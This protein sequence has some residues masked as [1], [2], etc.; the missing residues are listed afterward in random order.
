MTFVEAAGMGNPELG[1]VS[2]VTEAPPAQVALYGSSNSA[3][4]SAFFIFDT[5]IFVTE[6]FKRSCF[7]FSGE[8]EAE[9]SPSQPF[10]PGPSLP[11]IASVLDLKD[12]LQKTTKKLGM[13]L[14]RKV[15][16]ALGSPGG[17]PAPSLSSP[18]PSAFPQ[19]CF[20]LSMLGNPRVTLLDEPSTGMD[21]KAKQHM[22]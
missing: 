1:A 14:K 3:F 21:P 20:A 18:C 6:L 19:L 8:G 12:H 17:S 9:P 13:G 11:S 4:C 10:P 5:Q 16:G 22:W 2:V 15:W 7:A